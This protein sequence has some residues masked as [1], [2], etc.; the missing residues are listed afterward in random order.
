LLM[1]KP[2]IMRSDEVDDAASS[3]IL[4]HLTSIPHHSQLP[5]SSCWNVAQTQRQSRVQSRIL[6]Q[7]KHFAQ[8]IHLFLLTALTMDAAAEK[9]EE[10]INAYVLYACFGRTLR[11]C[12][13][14]SLLRPSL[15]V[16]PLLCIRSLTPAQ[17]TA[18]N[19]SG[20]CQE[21]HAS[22]HDF[23]FRDYCCTTLP[24][25]LPRCLLCRIHISLCIFRY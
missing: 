1:M 18:F 25:L 17:G 9:P 7:M 13:S 11:P 20:F 22:T 16:L 15:F 21:K 24:S 10:D 6:A 23:M 2:S 5:S 8:G 12:L 19:S 14:R 4:L 3:S